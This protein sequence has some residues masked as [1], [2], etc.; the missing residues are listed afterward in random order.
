MIPYRGAGLDNVYLSNGYTVRTLP[1]GEEAI[2]I[3]NLE[4]LH[5]AIAIELAGRQGKMDGQT[6]R[7]LRKFTDM[8][9]RAIGDVLGVS[10]LSVSNWERGKHEIPGSA[11]EWLRGFVRELATGNASLKAAV[12]R[13]N[14]LDREIRQMEAQLA[15][16]ET[17]DGWQR[18][19]A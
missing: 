16:E 8:G 10:E 4:G 11:A 15:F 18:Q 3:H 2:S 19:A 6:F 5:R 14:H 12:E 1:S 9:Q 13:H 17:N 7:F